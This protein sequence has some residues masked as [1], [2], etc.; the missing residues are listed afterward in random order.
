MSDR[1]RECRVDGDHR[2]KGCPECD[3]IVEVEQLE[4]VVTQLQKN[5]D[6]LWNGRFAEGMEK[7]AKECEGQFGTFWAEL[8]RTAAKEQAK[9]VSIQTANE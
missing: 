3:L 4:G 7:A 1:P 2:I 9:D 8:I 6:A 5:I